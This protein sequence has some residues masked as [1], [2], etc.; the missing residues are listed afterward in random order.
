MP[1]FS[2]GTAQGLQESQLV[3]YEGTNVIDVHVTRRTVCANWNSGNA[4]LGLHNA[5]GTQAITPP[6][7]NTGTW[8][9]NNES[10]RFTPSGN[11][12]TTIQWLDGA[13]VIGNTPSIAVCPTSTKTYTAQVRYNVC[14]TVRTVTKPITIEVSP[15]DTQPAQAIENCLPNNVFNL[16]TNEPTVLGPLVGTG[17]YEVYYYT[18]Q[19]DAENLAA[20]SIGNPSAY[21]LSSGTSQTIYMSLYN[22]FTGCIRIRPFTISMI[23]CSV[24]P[25][26][27]NPSSNQVLCEGGDPI[28]F[29]V[30]TSA[31]VANSIKFVYFNALQTGDAMY[32]GG[33]VLGTV[34]PAAGVAT[35][36]A[37]VLGTT[38]SLPNTPGTYYVYAVLNPTPSDATCRPN[39]LI[40]VVVNEGANAGTDGSVT[41]CETNTA[42]INL[43]TLI[44]G[45]DPGGTWVRT[46]GTGGVFNAAAGSF[47]PTAGSTSST[48]TYTVNGIPP[49]SNDSSVASVIIN[50][51]PDA[52]LDGQIQICETSVTTINLFSLI[53]GEETGGT[54]VRTTGTGGVFNATAG[55]FTPGAGV[56]TSTFTYT[57]V[58]AAPCVDDSSVATVNVVSQPNAGTSGSVFIC[59]NDPSTIDLSTVISGQQTGGVWTRTTGTGGVFNAAAGTFTLTVGATSSSFTYTISG[60]LP[61][62]PS[63]SIASVN[64][65]PQ[66]NAGVD[67]ATTVCETS[68]AA[69]DLFSLI[70]GEQT[71]GTW[72]RTSGSGGVFN[73]AAGTFTPAIGAT[74]SVFTYTLTGTTPCANDSSEVVVTVQPQPQAGIDGGLTICNTSTTVIDLFTLITGGQTGGTWTRTSGSGGTFN[75]TLGTFTPSLTTTS[76]T[77]T[78]TVSGVAP[79]IADSSIATLTVNVQPSAGNDGSIAVCETSTTAVN[80]ASLITGEQTGGIWTR[81]TGTGGTFDALAGTYTPAVGA[82]TST[83]TYTVNGVAPCGPDSSIATVSISVA[84][85]AGND[86]SLTVCQSTTPI[87]LADIITGEQLGGSWIRTGGTGGTFNAAAGT[88]IPGFN[89]TPSTFTYTV[90]GVAPCVSNS[91]IATV[92]PITA[93]TAN[94]PTPYEVC[95]DNNDGVACTFVLGTGMWTFPM[96]YPA[97]LPLAKVRC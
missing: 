8:V 25:T 67:G 27:T 9:A 80:L 70:T 55:T 64:I 49:C 63:S 82:T 41:I 29:G 89:A 95:D 88:F 90:F 65:V 74:S 50:S 77:F 94:T 5:T 78:Y 22:I 21:V 44:L 14:G 71:G 52:G 47:T 46:T 73:A 35:Y 42:T 87:N 39:Q 54:W 61:C 12:L 84:P 33:T 3:L 58:G 68:T 11:S 30:T 62:G 16:T 18:N 60:V 10:W 72:T 31:T 51:Q 76:S 23:D 56:T 24:C 7:R 26:I 53:S 4:V 28:V 79:C 83:F 43:N 97:V 93:P 45:Q 81:T 17:D 91:S 85:N 15:D 40:Q 96:R 57:I 48:F 36:D 66:S 75:A 6:G 2:C 32:T 34:T 37:G 92:N 38:G 20:N 19:S 1:L 13:T 69:I 86:G 59:S